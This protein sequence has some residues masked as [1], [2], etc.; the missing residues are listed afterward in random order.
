VSRDG[1]VVVIHDATL[2]R[3]TNARGSVETFTAKDLSA[4][5]AGYHFGADA[6][7]PYRERGIGVPRLAD[8]LDRHRRLPW[9]IEIKGERPETAERVVHVL[10]DLR[11]LDRVL[12]G[13]FSQRVLDTVRALAPGLP[14]GASSL[15][16]R[17]AARR[18]FFRLPIKSRGYAA[19]QVPLRIR[20]REVF[21]EPFVRRARQASL[22]VH[23]WVIDDPEDI[24]RL[25][26]WGVTG[27]I[28]DR[29]DVALNE[30]RPSSVLSAHRAPST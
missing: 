29:P 15:E 22:P 23:C 27:F 11:A 8:L 19:F 20:G 26:D 3:T 16:A 30:C 14:T 24:R 10:R 5:D 18:A 7:F 2:D 28:T 17:A 4:I 13:G 1:E 25:R 12:V 6:N 21:G 9:I